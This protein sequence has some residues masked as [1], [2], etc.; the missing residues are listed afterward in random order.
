[1]EGIIKNQK[2]V[3]VRGLTKKYGNFTAVNNVD[4]DVK[5]GEV[6]AILGPNGAGKT[7]TI[8][9][10]E[11]YRK[12]T[13]GEVNVLGSEPQKGD[14]SWRAK[15][16]MV[17]QSTS[18]DEEMTVLE[19]FKLYEQLYPNA[20]S[21]KEVIELVGLEKSAHKRI[22]QLS[23]GQQRRVDVGLGIIGRPEL[24]FLDEPTTGFDP[25]ARR[26]SW[27]MIKRLCEE[28]MSVILT[29]HYMDE[30]KFLADRVLVF[31]DGQIVANAQPDEVGGVLCRQSTIGFSVT[32][33]EL[34]STLPNDIGHKLS[35]SGNYVSLL[36]EQVYQAIEALLAWARHQKLE[37]TNLTVSRPSLED[38]YLELVRNHRA[39][40]TRGT[41]TV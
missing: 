15:L 1:M 10:L 26:D 33:P 24:L 39:L 34:L 31:V 21:S 22:G 38:V 14:R 36:T 37:L 40:Q 12:P 6:L 19:M 28:G 7:S 3:E 32:E 18:L 30:A 11:G 8:E 13:S 25:V 4:F 27:H 16:G 35:L 29:T 23:G 20:R 2:V 5:K 9:M 17:L 41:T